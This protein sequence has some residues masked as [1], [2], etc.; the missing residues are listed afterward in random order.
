MQCPRQLSSAVPALPV[1]LRLR[2]CK[3]DLPGS[4][5][6]KSSHSPQTT[7][8]ILERVIRIFSKLTICE[9]A[10]SAAPP[11]IDGGWSFSAS[12]LQMCQQSQGVSMTRTPSMAD[13]WPMGNQGTRDQR[14]IDFDWVRMLVFPC[15]RLKA[16][17]LSRVFDI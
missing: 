10:A 5:A 4:G 9:A 16:R 2:K 14:N 8:L 15:Q 13:Q 1:I 17:R 11:G 7:L 6:L 3:S 12:G